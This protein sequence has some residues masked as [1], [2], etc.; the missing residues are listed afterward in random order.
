M[1]FFESRTNWALAFSPNM[2]YFVSL[3]GPIVVNM[4]IIKTVVINFRTVRKQMAG[5]LLLLKIA[6]TN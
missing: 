6:H 3:S 4:H 5:C 2:T 1:S